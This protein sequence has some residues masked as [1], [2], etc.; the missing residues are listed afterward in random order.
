MVMASLAWTLKA[1]IALML[2]VTPRWRE[3]HELDRQLVLRMEF[4]SFLQHL[5]LIP[6]PDHPQRAPPDLPAFGLAAPPAGPVS[7]ARRTLTLGSID[8]LV[9]GRAVREPTTHLQEARQRQSDSTARTASGITR[10]NG[11]AWPPHARSRLPAGPWWGFDI[12]LFGASSASAGF[13][14]RHHLPSQTEPS[15]HRQ[16]VALR[17]GKTRTESR[18]ARSGGSR[19]LGRRCVGGWR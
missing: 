19:G 1:W 17:R 15:P 3:Q 7:I 11:C 14:R 2:P 13:L 18:T 4:R 6:R 16:S 10:R 12:A 9:P 8:A 5:I